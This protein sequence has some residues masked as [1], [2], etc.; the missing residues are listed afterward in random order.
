[1]IK[2]LASF[3]EIHPKL[4]KAQRIHVDFTQPTLQ[5]WWSDLWD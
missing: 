2:A 4:F 3:V 1:M 5:S